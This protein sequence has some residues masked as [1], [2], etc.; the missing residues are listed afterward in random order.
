MTRRVLSALSVA[1]LAIGAA[2]YGPGLAR[3]PTLH[4]TPDGAFG[5]DL[6]REPIG[7]VH[8]AGRLY[9]SDAG[10]DRIV[11]FDT[12][13]SVAQIWCD[14]ALAG[15]PM[16]LGLTAD[17]GVLVP[18]YLRDRVDIFA[19][20]G[21]PRAR[22]GGESGAAP[23]RM[24]APAGAAELNGRLYIAD[25]YNHRID[26]L[27]GDAPGVL[28]APGRVL[29]GRLHYPTDVAADDSLLYVADAYN[30]RIQVFRQDGT[31]VRRWG[32]PFGFG[33]RG[34]LPGWFRVATGIE[35][36]DGRVYVADF[37][38]DRVQVFT[39]AGRYLG[40]I[41][42][43]LKHPTDVAV[44]ADGAVYVVDFGNHRIVRFRTR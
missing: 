27:Q 41:E 35:V 10:A 12:T 6:L 42:A 5:D 34:G 22:I 11:V 25:F 19:A 1:V 39:P 16:H 15:R 24:D 20:D 18:L 37:E 38:N 21:E 4:F 26:V 40:R 29:G 3:R 17:G 7:I 30:H 9:V 43:D 31:L 36:A 2:L 8:R 13:G 33:G 28:G 44:G 14:S 32:G 23:G